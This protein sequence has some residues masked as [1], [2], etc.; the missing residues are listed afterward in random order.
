[1]EE[2]IYDAGHMDTFI[3]LVY[4]CFPLARWHS[5]KI[6]NR[7][8]SSVK[9]AFLKASNSICGVITITCK[10]K[11]KERAIIMVEIHLYTSKHNLWIGNGQTFIKE[12]EEEITYTEHSSLER[13]NKGTKL[14][15]T[16]KQL[17]N[18]QRNLFTPKHPP[19]YWHAISWQ[20]NRII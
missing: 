9:K 6:N 14:L 10:I 1:M 5:S 3:I 17:Q 11:S 4:G 13:R 19:Y 7:T 16:Q 8:M 2:C 18:P 15:Y 20:Q 12:K